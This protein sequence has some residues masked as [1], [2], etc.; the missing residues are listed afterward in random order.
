[1]AL[2]EGW[3]MARLGEIGAVIT[4]NTPSKKEKKYYTDR[5]IN[6]FK[7]CDLTSDNISSLNKSNDFLSREGSIKGRIVPKDSVLITCIGIIGKV[8]IV[9]KESCFNQQIN[10]VV[11]DTNAIVPQYLSYAIYKRKKVLEN[12]SNA[13]VVPIINKSQFSLFQIPLPPLPSQHKIVEILE[14][15][16]RLRKLRRKADEKMKDLIPALFVKMFG[17]PATNQK[18]WEVKTLGE[19]CQYIKDGPHV[20]PKYTAKGIPFYSVQNVKPSQWIFEKVKYISEE[21]HKV[22]SKRCSPEYGDVLYSKGGSTGMAKFVDLKYGFSIWVHLAL[23]KINR[24]II[25]GRFLEAMLNLQ[26]CYSQSQSFTGGIANRDLV[27]KNMK[28]ILIFLPPLPLQQEFAERVQ[29]IEAEK[30]RQAKSRAK[31]DD[32]F[33]ALMQRAFKGELVA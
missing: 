27:L 33:N 26:Y 22:F 29:E 9:E 15:A 23:L 5:Y 13:P 6:F 3:K 11:P 31:L 20:S 8:G 10:A 12:L 14:E 32:L 24:E 2:P 18:G 25:E 16:D 7:P 1:M 30:E 4:G 17:D 21:D 28:R 19:V